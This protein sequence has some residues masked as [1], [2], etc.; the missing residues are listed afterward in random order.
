MAIFNSFLYVHQRV[1]GRIDAYVTSEVLHRVASR[2]F[3]LKVTQ[4]GIGHTKRG[5]STIMFCHDLQLWSFIN[6]NWLFQ[7]DK[8]HSINGVF[9]VLITGISGLNCRTLL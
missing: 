4:K 9:L 6:Y 5:T 7:W 2:C 8:K 3:A 1:I